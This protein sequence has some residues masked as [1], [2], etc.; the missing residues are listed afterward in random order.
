[1]VSLQLWPGYIKKKSNL[2]DYEKY[3]PGFFYIFIII[4]LVLNSSLLLNGLDP[5]KKVSEYS[6]KT[7]SAE[8]GLP[9]SSILSIIQTRDGYLWMATYEG[10]VRFDGMEFRIYNT[11]N[12]SEIASDRIKHLI[13]DVKGKIWAGTSRGLLCFSKGKFKNFTAKDGLLSDYVN[14]IFEDSSRRLWIGTSRGFYIHENG[15]FSLPENGK[16]LANT[17]ISAIV[18]GNNGELWIGTYGKGLFRFKN[19]LL[20][21]VPVE[22]LP[23]NIDIRTLY[24]DMEG[25]LWLGTSGNGLIRLKDGKFRVYTTQ[26]GLS[27]NHI[28]AIMRDSQGTLWIGTNGE[29]INTLKDN[30]FSWSKYELAFFNSP[31]RVLFEDKE[32]S[33]WVGTRDGLAHLSDGKF[34]CYNKWNGLP[35]D[36][37]RSVFQDQDNNLWIGTVSGGLVRFKNDKFTTFKLK[38][39]LKSENIWTIC[40]DKNNNLFFGTYGGGLHQLRDN[41]IV[42][43]YSTLNGLSSNIIRAVYVDRNNQIWVG[44][45]GGGV[46]LLK[47][48]RWHNL[49]TKNGL[50]G[51]FIYAINEDVNGHIW[52]ATYNGCLNKYKDGKLTVYGVK[53][54][55]PG[56][57]IWSLYPDDK[58]V[59]WIGT[60]GGGLLRFKDEKFFLYTVKD[61]L[62]SNLAFQIVEDHHG[63]LW[64]NCNQGIYRVAKESLH[65]FADGKIKKIS[66]KSYGKSEGLTT[67]CSGPAQPAGF[68]SK[69]GKL[70][71]PTLRGVVV[72]DP[73]NAKKNEYIP[74]VIIER[75]LV[76]GKT[77][78]TYSG[79]DQEEIMLSPG[80]KRIEFK[81]SGLSYINSEGVIYKYKLEGFDDDWIDAG[82]GRIGYYNNVDP[83]TYVFKVLA[84]NNDGTWNEKGTRLS[85]TLKPFL[86]QTIWFKILFVLIFSLFSYKIIGFI[87]KYMKLISFWEKKNIIGS[88]EIEEKIGSGGMGIV[89]K[90][91][92]LMDKSSIFA[93]KIMKD[94]FLYDEV[95]KRRFKNESLLIDRFSHPNI[96]KVFEIGEDK[97]KLYFVMELLDGT[98]LSERFKKGNYPGTLHCIHIMQQITDILVAIH[99]ENIV[100]RDLKPENIMLI[101]K[102]D[103]CNYLK[104]LDFGIAKMQSFSNLTETGQILGTIAYLPPEAVS[105]GIISPAVDI[106]SLGIIGYEMLTRKK[107]FHKNQ[108][109]ETMKMIV[110]YVPP[111]P[112]REVPGIPEELNALIY[113]MIDKKPAERPDA[114]EVL[115]S[116]KKISLSLTRTKPPI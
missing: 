52:I 13:E 110:D 114:E 2:S 40:Q 43:V 87:R 9:Q 95:Q 56:H 115:Q 92:S 54:G 26:D 73:G 107:L 82:T 38:D 90:V 105:H 3:K 62:Y 19:G 16:I 89:Y 12:T 99:R 83:G 59:L 61:G 10:I 39:G 74:P 21:S 33:V 45:N 5:N 32:G 8:D 108:L 36:N 18:E 64:M 23:E 69:D 63:Y 71:F 81:Y 41:K 17:S 22:G 68:C 4:C 28:R 42:K 48:G 20:V 37:T 80:K 31:I 46:D 51:D 6:I 57:S 55:L 70:W 11:M 75:M 24:K 112:I 100:H 102:G 25:S 97:G 76:N 58:G 65:D 85:F 88:Y 101:T 93:V 98:L 106:Y 30:S 113:K 91:H 14:V 49:S 60:D 50:S 78:Y 111:E 29:G 66:C 109:V 116:L 79:Q 47:T 44:T 103:D 53:E 86:W 84:G 67:E 35:V 15:K 27:D 94:E 96:V 7:Y 1:M 34:I 77:I 72:I 104:L